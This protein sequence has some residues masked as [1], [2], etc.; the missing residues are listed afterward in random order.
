M[1]KVL[2]II[3]AAL[4]TEVSY[5]SLSNANSLVV[6]VAGNIQGFSNKARESLQGEKFWVSQLKIAHEDLRWELDEPKREAEWERELA[7]FEREMR[8][9]DAEFYKEYP[10]MRPSKTETR[11]QALRDKADQLEQEELDRELEEDRLILINDLRKTIKYI[12]S[13]ISGNMS[14]ETFLDAYAPHAPA[15]PFVPSS[16]KLFDPDHNQEGF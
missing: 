7:E 10:D 16:T 8:R 12:E 2:F 9:E 4:I 13:K 14:I 15:Q 5:L 6:T 3:F 11:V 1:Y